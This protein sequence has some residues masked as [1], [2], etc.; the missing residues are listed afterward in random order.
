MMIAGMRTVGAL[1]LMR[2]FRVSRKVQIGCGGKSQLTVVRAMAVDVAGRP[3]E[4]LRQS[5]QSPDE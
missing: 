2:V 3:G 5:E 4:L 1:L